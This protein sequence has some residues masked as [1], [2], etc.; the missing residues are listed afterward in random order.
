ENEWIEKNPGEFIK[1]PKISKQKGKTQA[2]S[3]DEIKGIL[4]SLKNDFLNADKPSYK[5]EHYRAWLVYGVFLTMATV[6]MRSSE[7]VNLKISDFAQ[8]GSFYRLHLNL[9]GGEQ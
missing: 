3:E 8:S 1:L 9:K 5:K 6:G 4:E 2:L 7:L